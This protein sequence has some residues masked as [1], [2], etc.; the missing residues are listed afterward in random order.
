MKPGMIKVSVLYQGGDAKT[1]NLDYYINT[2][3]PMAK[4][5]LGSALKGLNV[6]KGLGGGEPGSA[7]TYLACAHL[8]FDSVESF[9]NS[10]G[11]NAEKI[12]A[13]MV[14]YTNTAPVIQISEVID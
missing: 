5:L 2:H 4:N 11:P 6:E 10:F 1:F 12:G 7:P 13:D 3:I 14:N 9:Q 8:F